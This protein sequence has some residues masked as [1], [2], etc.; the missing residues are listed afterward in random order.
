[1]DFDKFYEMALPYIRKV[2]TRDDDLKKIAAMVKSRIEIFPDI[3]GMIDFFETLPEYDVALY[4]NKKWKT[5]PEKSLEII[6]DLLP[7]LE[8]QEDYSNDALYDVLKSYADEKGYK[9]GFVIWPVRIAVSGKQNT[10]AGATEI[11]EVIGKEETI[12][13]FRKAIQLLEN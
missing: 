12:L 13:R 8:A 6:K 5:T 1:M 3:A 4:T 10:P 9:A 11:M 7:V 2:I